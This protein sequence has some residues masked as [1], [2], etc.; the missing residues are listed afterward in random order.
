M[1]HITPAPH[2]LKGLRQLLDH[3][4]IVPVN[5]VGS[6]DV[7]SELISIRDDRVEYCHVDVQEL[8][9]D[10]SFEAVMS[11]LLK[12]RTSDMDE[13]ADLSSVLTDAAT[14][15]QPVVE[16]IGTVPLQT[17]PLDLL[18]LSV[19]LL[20]CFDPTPDDR[21]LE[22]SQSQFW[23]VMAQLPVLFH[24][25]FGGR[26]I[27]GRIVGHDDAAPLSYAGRLLQVLRDD[28]C[29]PTAAEERAMNT[30]MICE[31]LTEMRPACLLARFFGSAVNDSVAGLKAATSLYVSQLR[32]D[33]FLWTTQKL[34]GFQSPQDAHRWWLSRQS[35]SMPFGFQ[36]AAE[37]PRTGIL[38]NECREL[39]GSVPAMVLESC[40]ARLES[41]QAGQQKY[42]TIDWA[43]ARTLTLLN[44]PEDRI[45]L[46]IGI[47]RMVG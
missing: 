20:S 19:A 15:D 14:V 37:D 27:D 9:D 18:P 6:G 3:V 11:L 41:L 31:C 28:H 26:L 47:A 13:L 4:G 40:A 16:T 46:A 22:A 12:R 30:V 34:R 8:C 17:R 43:A 21:C 36:D 1:G 7:H 45:S 29:V 5:S 23:R 2:L 33:P 39:L 35:R 32:N 10:G 42:P 44:V 38:R 24:V 25:A